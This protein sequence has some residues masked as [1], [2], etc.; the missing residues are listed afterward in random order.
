[1]LNYGLDYQLSFNSIS[2]FGEFS[3]SHN[4]GI[5][6]VAGLDTRLS[7]RLNFTLLYRYFAVKYHNLFNN[8][9]GQSSGSQNEHGLYFGITMLLTKNLSLTGYL[10]YYRFPWL[11]YLVD[12]PSR[13][14]DFQLQAN[15]SPSSTLSMHLRFRTRKK[16]QNHNQGSFYSQPLITVDKHDWRFFISCQVTAELTLRSRIDYVLVRSPK[17]ISKGYLMY[18]DLLYRPLELPFNLTF[19]YALF[20]TDGFES[21]IYTYENDVYYAFSIPS[22]S[23]SG[24]R[25]YLMIKGKPCKGLDIWIRLARTIYSNRKSIGTGC[26]EIAGNKKTEIRVQAVLKL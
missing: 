11:R 21:R 14:R 16:Q 12:A 19:R 18:Q 1:L 13:G 6:G 7:E 4:G 3:A 8:P 17:K 26:D 9:F 25:I 24:Q 15:Y 23:G 2:L 22:Y 20:D 5:A 10:D